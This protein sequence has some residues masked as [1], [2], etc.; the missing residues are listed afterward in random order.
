MKY[1]EINFE[2]FTTVLVKTEEA[3]FHAAKLARRLNRQDCLLGIDGTAYNTR[4]FVSINSIASPDDRQKKL[5][6]NLDEVLF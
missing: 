3:D 5:A 4:R 6:K 1:Y 2:N